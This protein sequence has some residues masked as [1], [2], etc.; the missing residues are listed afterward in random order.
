MASL[1]VEFS[2]EHIRSKPWPAP[3]TLDEVRSFLGLCGYYRCF[4]DNYADVAKPLTGMLKKGAEYVWGKEQQRSFRTLKQ[5]LISYPCLGMIRPEGRLIV[6]TDASDYAIGAVLSQVQDGEERVLAYHSKT[7]NDA[8]TRYCTTKKELLAM[9]EA[10]EVWDHYLQN[11]SESFLLRTDHAALKWLTTMAIKDRTLSRWAQ[12]LAEYN[13]ECEHRPG[14]EHTNADSLSR[15]VY[16]PC[17]FAGCTD[18]GD[19]KPNSD[20]LFKSDEEVKRGHG[21]LTVKRKNVKTILSCAVTRSQRRKQRLLAS[22]K[23]GF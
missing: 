9:K 11:P 8:Q 2:R 5:A 23:P 15:V 4:V 7:L 14:R 3:K 1:K 18:C 17:E 21:E 10:L 22:E 20:F 16:R 19:R 13:F 6:D 12:F